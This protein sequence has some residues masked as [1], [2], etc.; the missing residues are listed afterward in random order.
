MC[1][2]IGRVV[3][4]ACASHG[5]GY[6]FKA[7]FDKANRT[8]LTSPRGPGVEEGLGHLRAVRDELGVP[9]TTDVHAPEQAGAVA[10]VVDLLQIP[11]FLCRQTDLLTAVAREAGAQGKGVNIKK[12]QFLSPSEMVGPVGKVRD[13]GCSSIVLTERGTF[14]GYNRLVNDFIGLG[15]M[16]ELD[17]QGGSPPVCFDATH[18]AQLPGAS[19]TTG[20]RRERVPTLAKAAVAA[21]VDAIFLECHP[22]PERAA[23]DASTMLRLSDVPG[24]IAT[25]A[26]VR[27]AAIG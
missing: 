18:S 25:L 1:L 8:S 15:D 13:A 9:V 11:A 7:S 4:K 23:S 2:E 6:V 19:T 21:G 16:M 12:G 22:D 20:G 3:Q 10:G 27:K 24:L 5:L 14:F 17:T 26:A